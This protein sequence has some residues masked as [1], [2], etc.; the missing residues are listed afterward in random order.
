MGRRQ[1]H[2]FSIRPDQAVTVAGSHVKFINIILQLICD[3]LQQ[4]SRILRTDFAGAVIYNRSFLIRNILFRKSDDIA[5]QRHIRIFHG[6]ADAQGFQ[7]GTARI[8]FS[9]IITDH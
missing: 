3:S 7:R 4:N 6:H 1:R 5:A 2:Y 8:I 9:G